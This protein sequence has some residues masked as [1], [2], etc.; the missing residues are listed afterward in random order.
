MRVDMVDGI[1]LQASVLDSRLHG[2]YL[3]LDVGHYNMLGVACLPKTCELRVYFSPPAYGLFF[4]LQNEYPG[5][6]GHDETCP[7]LGE[8]P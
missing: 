8:R 5:T 7:T 4:P 1:R 2:R 6:L 3:T